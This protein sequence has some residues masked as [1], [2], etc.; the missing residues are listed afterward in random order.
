MFGEEGLWCSF[1]SLTA[2]KTTEST[3]EIFRVPVTTNSPSNNTVP[4]PLTAS[5]AALIASVESSPVIPSTAVLS[6]PN[7]TGLT[8]PLYCLTHAPLDPVESADGA[9]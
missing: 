2:S 3:P 9:T 1:A 8:G 4:P 7:H 5:M 6:A